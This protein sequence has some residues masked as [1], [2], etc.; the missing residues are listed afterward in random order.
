[1][2]AHVDALYSSLD[3]SESCLYDSI[4]CANE[5]YDG[6]ICGYARIY[7]EQLYAFGTND[8]PGYFMNDTHVASLAEIG[9]TFDKRTKLIFLRVILCHVFQSH[10][11]IT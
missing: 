9:D 10:Y 2:L 3:G 11:L 4:W 6:T 8:F 5:G 1:M 7:M